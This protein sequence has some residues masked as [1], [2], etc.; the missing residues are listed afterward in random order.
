MRGKF[1]TK[2]KSQYSKYLGLLQKCLKRNI[3]NFFYAQMFEMVPML[4][5][6][7]FLT[8]PRLNDGK[9]SHKTFLPSEWSQIPCCSRGHG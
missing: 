2:K 6:I 8:E 4:F 3:L 9:A 7:V 5:R 1:L